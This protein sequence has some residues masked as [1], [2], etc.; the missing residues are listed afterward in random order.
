MDIREFYTNIEGDF[1]DVLKRMRKEER[2]LKYV[3]LF[4]QDPSYEGLLKSMEEGD[5]EEGFRMAHSLKG[6]CQNLGFTRLEV[7]ASA[8]T[9]A[10]REGKRDVEL[11][12]GLLTELVREYEKTI[13]FIDIITNPV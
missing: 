13:S 8:V 3:N 12:K 5:Y 1:D 10:L 2:I 7:P 11:A 9:E 4:V 6:V